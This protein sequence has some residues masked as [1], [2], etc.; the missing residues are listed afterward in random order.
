MIGVYSAT[1]TYMEVLHHF[2]IM[3]LHTCGSFTFPYLNAI[4]TCVASVCI[5]IPL[6]TWNIVS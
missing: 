2:I 3:T 6:S 4:A 5:C 1:N